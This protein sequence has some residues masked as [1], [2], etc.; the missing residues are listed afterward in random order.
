[1]RGWF[2]GFLWFERIACDAGLTFITSFSV[3][4]Y[5]LQAKMQQLKSN[6]PIPATANRIPNDIQGGLD[7]KEQK[8]KRVVQWFPVVRKNRL[9]CRVDIYCVIQVA[10]DHDG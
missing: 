6:P 7:E 1:M 4:S 9:R 3:N 10:P 8:E 5:L 2:T